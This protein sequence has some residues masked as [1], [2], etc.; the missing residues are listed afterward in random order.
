MNSD[1]E[2]LK[3]LVEEFKAKVN[4][5][6]YDGSNALHLAIAKNA[7][8]DILQYLLDHGCKIDK[9]TVKGPGWQSFMT[10]FCGFT[11]LMM[12]VNCEYHNISV[13]LQAG[14]NTELY[15]GPIECKFPIRV[16]KI[17]RV[18]EYEEI[19]FCFNALHIAASMNK[20]DIV[21]ELLEHGKADPD[22]RVKLPEDDERERIGM[23]FENAETHPFDQESEIKTRLELGLNTALHLCPENSD[24]AKLLMVNGKASFLAQNMFLEAAWERHH[25]AVMDWLAGDNLNLKNTVA[26]VC[27][28]KNIPVD[29]ARTITEYYISLHL[30][31]HFERAFSQEISTP[32]WP[33]MALSLTHRVDSARDNTADEHEVTASRWSIHREDIKNEIFRRTVYRYYYYRGD[34][35]ENNNFAPVPE[36]EDEVKPIATLQFVHKELQRVKMEKYQELFDVIT[37]KLYSMDIFDR[38]PAQLDEG[39]EGNSVNDPAEEGEED[40]GE[41]GEPDDDDESVVQKKKRQRLR[42]ES[43]E[44]EEE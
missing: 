28:A 5:T 9:Q 3:V 6:A 40:D 25:D 22:A 20:E 43:S 33:W 7:P 17:L 41:D 12:A 26:A 4:V 32:Y 2:S 11:P 23:D 35:E 1:L 29:C 44:N 39:N 36:P 34:D 21:D 27:V 15:T 24:V 31:E 8:S 18:F 10:M 19:G 30:V 42:E 16:N 13:L 37:S 38:A 14:A